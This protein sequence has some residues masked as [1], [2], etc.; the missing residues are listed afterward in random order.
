MTTVGPKQQGASEFRLDLVEAADVV[1]TDWLAQ[2]HACNPPSVVASFSSKHIS[3]CLWGPWR[4]AR[5]QDGDTT[6]T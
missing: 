1:V 3:F 5:P 2:L 4:P 6:P